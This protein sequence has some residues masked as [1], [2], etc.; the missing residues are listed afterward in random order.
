[1]DAYIQYITAYHRDEAG[2]YVRGEL[3]WVGRPM[4]VD[5]E[6][7]AAFRVGVRPLGVQADIRDRGTSL[8]FN[9]SDPAP[10]TARVVAT[11]AAAKC[12]TTQI[13]FAQEGVRRLHMKREWETH[14]GDAGGRELAREREP[15]E[16]GRHRRTGAVW[17]QDGGRRWTA[18][19][20]TLRGNVGG[21][22]R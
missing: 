14:S 7:R 10:L 20:G 5:T 8:A 22:R 12:T 19:T 11:G 6:L 4:H 18:G 1:M 2:L 9:P 21:K 15:R 16:P 17:V 3:L 13:A